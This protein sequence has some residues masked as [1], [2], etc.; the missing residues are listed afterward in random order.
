[1]GTMTI[2][3]NDRKV[4]AQA[5]QTILEAARAAGIDIPTLCH[6]PALAPAGACRVCLVEVAGQRTLQPAC[7]F[8]AA[9]RMEIQTESPKVVAARRFVLELIFSERNHFCMT[10]PMSGDCELQS[11]G[12]RY[13]LDHFIYPTYRERFP[14]DASPAYH[15]LDHNRCVLCRRCVRACA[16]LVGNHTLDLRQRGAL[17]MLCADMDVPLADSSCVGCGTCVDVCPTGALIGKHSAFMARP[18]ELE[19]IATTCSQ[20]SLGCGLSVV[21]HRGRAVRLESLWEAAV[22]QGLLCRRGR[23]EALEDSRRRVLDPWLGGNGE[24]RAVSWETALAAAAERLKQSD[25]RRL[26]LMTTTRVTNEAIR[27]MKRIFIAALHAAQRGVVGGVCHRFPSA[28]GGRLIDLPGCDAILVAGA[29]PSTDHP[30]AAFMIKRAVDR[31]ARLITAGKRA[32]ELSAFAGL[33]VGPRELEVAVDALGAAARPM[34]VYGSDLERHDIRTLQR[35]AG[36]A[37]FLALHPGVN[38]LT[39]TALGASGP[40]DPAGCDT[41]FIISGEENGTMD[42]LASTVAP[43]TFVI[44]Q[45]SYESPLTERADLVLPMA[46]WLERSG[47]LTNTEGVLVRAHAALPPSGRSRPDWD[48]LGRLAETLGME[49]G[50]GPPAAGPPAHRPF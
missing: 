3:I 2:T 38:T 11:L 37:R 24:R 18:A 49:A 28:E 31:G 19:R 42:A 39:A 10:C 36:R 22:N 23:F 14:V 16:E 50:A 44:V 6:H 47:T 29:D 30:V 12:Y 21:M 9:D 15:L 40:L 45:A 48:I 41:L 43:R 5:G 27:L 32:A 1:M 35:L 7:T 25:P 26:G 4:S 34:V 8:P 13:G 17:T 46:G 33:H 20:C